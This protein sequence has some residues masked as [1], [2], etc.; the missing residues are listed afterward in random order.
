M[1]NKRG[2]QITKVE[3]QERIAET[4][5]M[6]L[7]LESRRFIVDELSAK[8]NITPKS[9]DRIISAAYAYI[10]ENYR[11]DRESIVIKHLEFYYDLAKKYKDVD[12]KAALKAM[13][14][15]E[16]LLKLHQDQPLIQQNT[17]NLNLENVT[18]EQLMKAIEGIKQQK[19]DA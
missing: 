9:C 17:L 8:Y 16:K 5:A 10:R 2:T 14:Q 4:A 3:S 12:P 13:E 18:D 1:A 15:I 6:L 19:K 7:N 11:T